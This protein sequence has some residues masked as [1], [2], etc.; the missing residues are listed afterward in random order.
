M[1]GF[2]IMIWVVWFEFRYDEMDKLYL[3]WYDVTN[4]VDSY[5]YDTLQK[6]V[7]YIK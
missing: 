4:V 2:K 3:N 6:N 5:G 7:G 1:I